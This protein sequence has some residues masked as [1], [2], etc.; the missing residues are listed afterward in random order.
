M[1]F[2]VKTVSQ[3][4]GIPRPTLVAWERRYNLLEPRRSPAGYRIYSEADVAYLRE[5]KA[6]VDGGLAISEAIAHAG[7]PAPAE[8]APSEGLVDG[9][10]AALAAYDRA[11]AD[12]LLPRLEQLSFERA[13]DE[14]HLPLLRRLGD[15]WESGAITVA[16]EHYASG[17]V[18]E[19]MSAMFHALD[20]GVRGGRAVACATAPGELHELGLLDL[21]IRLARRGHDVAWL[22]PEVPLPDLRA[23]L[24]RRPTEILCLS[25]LHP[26]PALAAYVAGARAAAPDTIVAV[27]GPGATDVVE[28]P[29]VWVCEDA[30]ELIARLQ[31]R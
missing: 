11:A 17:W 28:G 23:F 10:A 12:R 31:E 6:L 21:A 22:G 29:R 13:L 4:T 1:S 19:R 20:A 8:V 27:G 24:A 15:D 18:R 14:V 5:L 9:L 25:A 3:L 2:R 16:Q 30:A 7:A 26:D